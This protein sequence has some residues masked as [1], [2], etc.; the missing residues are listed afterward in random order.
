MFCIIELVSRRTSELPSTDLLSS[1]V[2]AITDLPE[3]VAVFNASSIF[4]L[5]S[6]KSATDFMLPTILVISEY[7]SPTVDA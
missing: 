3:F 1:T 7:E 4:K 2:P 5:F 6:T